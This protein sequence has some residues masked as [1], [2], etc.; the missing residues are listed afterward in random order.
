MVIR[1]YRSCHYWRD[2]GR[3]QRCNTRHFYY[4]LYVGY[5]LQCDHGRYCKSIAGRR[6]WQH[7]YLPGG[8]YYAKLCRWRHVDIRSHWSC[9]DR[10]KYGYGNWSICWGCT[11]YL[12]FTHRLC[13]LYFCVSKYNTGRDLWSF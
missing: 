7:Q 9:Y 13:Y 11:H 4:Y 6:Y 3:A 10:V 8:K 2:Y 12:Y 1:F 5:R